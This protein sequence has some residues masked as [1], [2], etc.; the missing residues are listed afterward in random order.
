M[1]DP[2]RLRQ[3][4]STQFCGHR[5]IQ[6]TALDS[7]NRVLMDWMGS[8]PYP[9]G[10]TLVASRQIAGRGQ[11]QRT[12][13]SPS[14]GLY[15]SVLLHPPGD[16]RLPQLTIALGWGILMALKDFSQAR[17][18]SPV[19]D[20]LGV[21]W[22][23]DLVASGHKLGGILTQARWQGSQ[24][25]GV[26]VGVGLNVNN[27]APISLKQLS[28]APRINLTDTAAAVL[29]GIEQGYQTWQCSGLDPLLPGYEQWMLHRG[30]LIG[31]ESAIEGTVL[32]VAASGSLRVQT[33][34]GEQHFPPGEIRL[35]YRDPLAP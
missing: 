35:G 23:N 30:S 20:Q 4:L 8:R 15:L 19:A 12:W 27:P 17:W 21:K 33:Q 3:Q 34:T 9:E 7:T 1:L 5:L 14:G 25:L 28:Q 2:V 11:Q 16:P 18:G 22:P 13:L 26:V 6:W 31:G 32:G 24:L 10:L 29:R